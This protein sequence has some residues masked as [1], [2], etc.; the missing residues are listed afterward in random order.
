[1]ASC[2]IAEPPPPHVQSGISSRTAATTIPA[3]APRGSEIQDQ[4]SQNHEAN[5][6]PPQAPKPLKPAEPGLAVPGTLQSR[7]VGV[8]ET[9][10]AAQREVAPPQLLN[11]DQVDRTQQSTG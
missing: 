6:D 1:M 7:A 11:A 4:K 9:D 8:R 5:A 3:Q 10:L 2:V